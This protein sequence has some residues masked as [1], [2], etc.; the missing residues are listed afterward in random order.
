ML[1]T[2]SQVIRSIQ[3]FTEG[4]PRPGLRL[5]RTRSRAIKKSIDLAGDQT[6][7]MAM[8]A[9]VIFIR[10][11]IHDQ[12]ELDAYAATVGPLLQGVPVRFLAA[13]GRQRVLEGPQPEGVATAEFP[14]LE[15][16][17]AWYENPAYQA[18]AQHRFKGATYRDFIVEGLGDDAPAK[19]Q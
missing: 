10:E 16:A 15:E 18:A 5:F 19:S 13:Y 3:D 12:A 17:I 9:Y 6:K 4:F 14:A 2:E 8:P 7:G 11:R 1:D